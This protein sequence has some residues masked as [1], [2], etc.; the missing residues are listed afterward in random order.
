MGVMGLASLSNDIVELQYTSVERNYGIGCACDAENDITERYRRRMARSGC[1]VQLAM[2]SRCRAHHTRGTVAQL[3]T[4]AMCL[5]LLG[6]RSCYRPFVHGGG[7]QQY[8]STTQRDNGDIVAEAGASGYALPQAS[9]K[10]VMSTTRTR[11]FKGRPR[12]QD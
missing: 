6:G 10:E 12:E 4:L 1:V 9:G 5:P 11:L 3:T 8:G 7:A 2:G